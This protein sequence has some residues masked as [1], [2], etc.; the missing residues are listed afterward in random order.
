MLVKSVVV[1]QLEGRR[2]CLR[3]ETRFDC[4]FGHW[5]ALMLNGGKYFANY[6]QQNKCSLGT[7]LML[8]EVGQLVEEEMWEIFTFQ[9]CKSYTKKNLPFEILSY[10]C[11]LPF[12]RQ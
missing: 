6:V 12:Q 9:L 3:I 11:N 1:M 10:L 4:E 8:V 2:L 5:M 7:N